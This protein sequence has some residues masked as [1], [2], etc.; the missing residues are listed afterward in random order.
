MHKLTMIF[1]HSG[2]IVESGIV[3]VVVWV[4]DGTKYHTTTKKLINIIIHTK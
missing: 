1:A 3:V 2:M 4:F